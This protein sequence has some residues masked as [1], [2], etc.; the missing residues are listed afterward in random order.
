MWLVLAFFSAFLLGVYDLFK[1]I[2]LTDNAVIPVLF[3]SIFFNCLFLLPVIL[4][5]RFCPDFIFHSP[6]YLPEMPAGQHG[7][8]FLK[9]LLVLTSWIFAYFSLKHLPITLA[10]PIKAFQPML[11]LTGAMLVFGERLNAWQWAGVLLAILSLYLLSRSGQKEGIRF[12]RNKWVCFMALAVVTGSLSGLYDKYLITRIDRM[13]LQVWSNYYQLLLIGIILLVLWYPKRRQTTPFRWKYTIP[14][15]S[16]FL[17][18]ADF[19]YFYSLSYPDSLISIVSLVRRSSV[20]V[21][22]TAGAILLKEKNL[23]LKLLDVLLILAGM[24]LIYL[25]TN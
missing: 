21:S 12:S 6:F 24:Y 13:N 25:G 22:F 14:L 7:W 19:A 23:R 8:L 16:G 4:L 18:M 17:L 20:I 3:W 2:S 15:I 5:S 1:K 10:S 9:A 11:T